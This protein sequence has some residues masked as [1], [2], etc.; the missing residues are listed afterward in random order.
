MHTT[1]KEEW[2]E[3]E[4]SKLGPLFRFTK[5]EFNWASKVAQIMLKAVTEPETVNTDEMKEFWRKLGV[6]EKLG[7]SIDEL[8]AACKWAGEWSREDRLRLG[9]LAVY[10]GFIDAHKSSTP[11][12]VA[13]ASQVMDL[14]KFENY[15]WGRVAFKTLIDSVKNADVSK[16][17]GLEGFA[18]VLQVWV[19]Y[20]MPRFGEENGDPRP[21]NP[22]PP[23]LAF[24]GI[25]GKRYVIGTMKK[26]VLFNHMVM[27]DRADVYPR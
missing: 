10:A 7:P 12:R 17:F 9:F 11:T 13:L 24:N 1:L 25:R 22:E 16:P 19:Y 23:L 21:N 27:V 15:P 14:E 5:L 18:E 3:L 20:A 2:D 4:N 6:N 8:I 26:Q